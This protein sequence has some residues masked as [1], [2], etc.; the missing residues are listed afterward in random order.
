MWRPVTTVWTLVTLYSHR[1]NP[2]SVPAHR[3]SAQHPSW[4]RVTQLHNAAII[5][6]SDL[7]SCPRESRSSG[8]AGKGPRQWPMRI[9]RVPCVAEAETR[10]SPLEGNG[11]FEFAMRG[12]DERG[13]V[14]SFRRFGSKGEGTKGTKETLSVSRVG[15]G[16][17]TLNCLA[18]ELGSWPTEQSVMV[19]AKMVIGCGTG[20]SAQPSAVPSKGTAQ[21]DCRVAGCR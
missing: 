10:P 9:V 12:N 19:K 3:Y 20:I 13:S 11:L 16:K 15:T 21:S 4:I 5:R 18:W 8:T 14:A 2:P 1:I 17:G 7:P 6:D